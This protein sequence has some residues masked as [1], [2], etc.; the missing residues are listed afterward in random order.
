MAAAYDSQRGVTVMFGGYDNEEHPD[1]ETWEFDGAAWH[2]AAPTHSPTPRFWHGMVYD[3]ARHLVVLFAGVIAGSNSTNETW[4]Y[5]GADWIKVTTVHEPS[6][7][8]GFGIAYDSCRQVVVAFGGAPNP[9]APGN[10]TAPTGRR[11]SLPLR[12][13]GGSS[14][15]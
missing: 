4:E 12:R 2:Q 14:P 5:N 13:A 6:W 8:Q 10:M 15:P 9:T 1:N 3:E 11:L 7:M